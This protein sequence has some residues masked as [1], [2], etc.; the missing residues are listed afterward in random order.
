MLV[1]KIFQLVVDVVEAQAVR[2][3]RVDLQRFARNAPLLIAADRVES[4]HVVQAVR[5]LDQDD[6]HVPRHRQKHLAVIL[7]LRL[8]VGFELDLVELGD[9]VHQIG[10]GLAEV[11]RDLGLGDGGVLHHVVE[12]RG[13]QRLRIEVPLRED[14]GDRQRMGDV[15][16]ARLAELALVGLLA[17]VIG[18]LQLRDVLRLEVAGPLLEQRW[19]GGGHLLQ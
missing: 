12:E 8:G 15:G 4:A 14:V 5:E 16:L 7:G 3:R 1:G 17:E 2:D 13:S 6:A 19:S 10:H 11:A 9:A 18:R